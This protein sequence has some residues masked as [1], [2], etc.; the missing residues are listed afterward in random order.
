VAC[1]YL[2][3]GSSIREISSASRC[4]ERRRQQAETDRASPMREANKLVAL[5]LQMNLH[6]HASPQT[7]NRQ[8]YLPSVRTTADRQP[9]IS[10]RGDLIK[11]I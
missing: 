6:P 2:R 5:T 11:Q 1:S 3:V 10:D 8:R 4:S 9:A 7:A